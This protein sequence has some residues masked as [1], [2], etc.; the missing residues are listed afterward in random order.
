MLPER[1]DYR[2]APYRK[3]RNANQPRRVEVLYRQQDGICAYCDRKMILASEFEDKSGL[4][5]TIDHIV[6]TSKGGTN[7]PSNLIGACYRCNN[8]K[9]DRPVEE[10]L[11]RHFRAAASA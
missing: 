8:L 4:R 2:S 11:E 10:F 7:H 9:G 3:P 6:P 1:V 5:C